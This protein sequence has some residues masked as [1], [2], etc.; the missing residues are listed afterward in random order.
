MNTA[1][2]RTYIIISVEGNKRRILVRVT[3]EAEIFSH[4]ICEDSF[5]LFA[6]CSSSVQG[7]SLNG[8]L[9]YPFSFVWV[10]LRILIFSSSP[11]CFE[12]SWYCPWRGSNFDCIRVLS[13]FSGRRSNVRPWGEHTHG[14]DLKRLF[15][16]AYRRA[17]QVPPKIRLHLTWCDYTH[18]NPPRVGSSAISIWRSLPQA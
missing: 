17:S 4:A 14:T 13:A 12:P 7:I 3:W 2:P 11:H 5:D 10:H 18:W 9:Y 6:L 1:S 8:E 15:V 16:L